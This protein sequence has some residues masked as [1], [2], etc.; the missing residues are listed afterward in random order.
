MPSGKVH[1]RVTAWLAVAMAAVSPEDAAG[2]LT[3]VLL[4]PDLDVDRGYYGLYIIRV[5]W[6]D[7]AERIWQAY[8]QPYAKLM[9]HRS[10]LSHVPGLSTAVRLAYLAAPAVIILVALQAVGVTWL[11]D[12]VYSPHFWRFLRGLV[13]ADTLHVVMDIAVTAWRRFVRRVT[14]RM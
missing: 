8:W 5:L 7:A 9:P 10:I 2:V 1:T 6:G 13:I 14:S 11:W 12:V 4:S 3:G